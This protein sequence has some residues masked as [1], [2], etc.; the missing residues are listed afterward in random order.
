[1]WAFGQN[2]VSSGA[3][4]GQAEDIDV[5]R[6]DDNRDLRVLLAD[7]LDYLLTNRFRHWKAGH[8]Q[9]KRLGSQL[10]QAFLYARGR[11]YLVPMFFQYYFPGYYPGLIV[12]KENPET[13]RALLGGI[14]QLAH[15]GKRTRLL[16]AAPF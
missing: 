1:M 9:V 10:I 6:E 2:H 13:F 8:H 14:D 3:L 4:L 15:P 5:S 11:Y 16:A 7:F 12:D